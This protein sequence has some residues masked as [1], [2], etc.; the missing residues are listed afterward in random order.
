MIFWLHTKI[1]I[2][3]GT[4]QWLIINSLDPLKFLVRAKKY[5]FISQLGIMLKFCPAVAAILDFQLTSLLSNH[6]VVSDKDI[7]G[8]L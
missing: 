5:L 1:G 2:L 4:I 3:W 7:F 8:S 6:S